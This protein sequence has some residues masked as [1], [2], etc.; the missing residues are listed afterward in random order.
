[1]ALKHLS[2]KNMV[3]LND[4]RKTAAFW[5]CFNGLR[6]FYGARR[7]LNSPHE[8]ATAHEALMEELLAMTPEEIFQTFVKAVIHTKLG[9]A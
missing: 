9:Q 6:T 8:N 5:A 4:E 7:K 2:Q 1:M 3:R